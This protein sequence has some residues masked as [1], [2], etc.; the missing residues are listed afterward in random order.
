MIVR[1]DGALLVGLFEIL[2]Q[3]VKIVKASSPFNFKM[4]VWLQSFLS[5]TFPFFDSLY[6]AY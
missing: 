1:G 3:S 2:F 5:L 6:V 4:S